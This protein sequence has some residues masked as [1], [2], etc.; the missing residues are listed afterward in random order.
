MKKYLILIIMACMSQI[1]SA[2]TA[3]EVINAYKDAPGVQFHS[4]SG[5]LIKASMPLNMARIPE[6]VDKEVLMTVFD[7]IEKLDVLVMQKPSDLDNEK[8]EYMLG[9]LKKGGYDDYEGLAYYKLEN[10]M[11]KDVLVHQVEMNSGM[12]V[13]IHITSNLTVQQAM[14]FAGMIKGFMK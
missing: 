14:Q 10:D 9:D 4:V 12:L 11:I 1:L 13:L 6:N 3:A 8:I 2:Q 7:N 5:E